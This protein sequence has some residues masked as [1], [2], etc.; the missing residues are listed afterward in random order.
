M[1]MDPRRSFVK[2]LTA[3]HTVAGFPLD[4]HGINTGNLTSGT[5]LVLF[6]IASTLNTDFRLRL[7]LAATNR[8]LTSEATRIPSIQT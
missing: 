3:Q 1:H 8:P 2:S 4:Q 7:L 5:T 6:P